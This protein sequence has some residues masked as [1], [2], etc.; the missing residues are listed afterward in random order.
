MV[1]VPL[2]YMIG[3]REGDVLHP[4]PAGYI[5]PVLL[6]LIFLPL[7]AQPLKSHADGR[8]QTPFDVGFELN[9]SEDLGDDFLAILARDIAPDRPAP[10]IGV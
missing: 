6:F 9:L 10:V 1:D 7:V 4:I 8:S 2:L 5:G 3:N